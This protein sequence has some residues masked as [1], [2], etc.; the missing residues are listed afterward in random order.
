MSVVSL[1]VVSVVSMEAHGI[2][3]VI[4]S[5]CVDFLNP[6]V[7]GGLYGG[8]FGTLKQNRGGRIVAWII[9]SA[10]TGLVAT[11]ELK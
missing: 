7:L 8:G 11:F 3:G 1:A 10:I 4:G 6:A 2:G 5:G 9:S